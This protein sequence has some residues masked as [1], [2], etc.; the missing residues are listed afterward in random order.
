MGRSVADLERMAR[1]LFGE[2]G[3]TPVSYRD[4]TLLENCVLGIVLM[5]GRA[6]LQ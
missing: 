4:V 5:V 6:L 2:R 3:N 1:L